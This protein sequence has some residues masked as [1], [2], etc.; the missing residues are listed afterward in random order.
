MHQNSLKKEI[1]SAMKICTLSACL[2]AILVSFIYGEQRQNPAVTKFRGGSFFKID[3]SGLVSTL[4]KYGN[5]VLP[6]SMDHDL[7]V[8][9][10]VCLCDL[11]SVD[12]INQE[13]DIQ[14]FTISLPGHKDDD[15]R[16][17]ALRVGRLFM[18][19][20]SY[21]RPSLEIELEN[22]DI[23]VEFTNLMLTKTNW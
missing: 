14:N 23:L 10:R 13:L 12:L 1:G 6:K 4:T 5:I 20:N 7:K 22:V 16:I 18:K 19:W 3:P 9:E 8:L 11:S 17:P 2:I 21:R 15:A